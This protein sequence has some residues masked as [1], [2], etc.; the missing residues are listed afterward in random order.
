MNISP[1]IKIEDFWSNLLT[2]YL[3]NPWNVITLI[4]DVAI[5]IFLFLLLMIKNLV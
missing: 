4:I 5:V 1:I 2:G 3:N